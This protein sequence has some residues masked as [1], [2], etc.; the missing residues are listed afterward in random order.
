MD[1]GAFQLKKT[2]PSTHPT[3]HVCPVLCSQDRLHRHVAPLS[4]LL[5][6][7]L[8]ATHSA[9]HAPQSPPAQ[10][11][12]ELFQDRLAPAPKRDIVLRRHVAS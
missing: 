7:A 3:E 6:T 2:A 11:P 4:W 10:T 9:L 5:N 1:L 8:L 12:L